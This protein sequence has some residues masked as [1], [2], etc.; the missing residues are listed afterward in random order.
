MIKKKLIKYIHCP[1]YPSIRLVLYFKNKGYDVVV[2]SRNP[3]V[4][5]LCKYMNWKMVNYKIE[6][7]LPRIRAFYKL[8]KY[9]QA[10]KR[11]LEQILPSVEKDNDLYFT[12]FGMDFDS[13]FIISKLSAFLRTFY[14]SDHDYQD[15]ISEKIDI[16]WKRKVVLRYLEIVYGLEWEIRS[17][18]G[19]KCICVTEDFFKRYNIK[20]LMDIVIDDREIYKNIRIDHGNINNVILGDYSFDFLGNFYDLGQVKSIYHFIRVIDNNTVYKGHP[21]GT[22]RDPFFA[23]YKKLPIFVPIEFYFRHI[24]NVISIDSTALINL[25]KFSNVRCL[26]LLD[27][28]NKNEKSAFDSDIHKKF[29]QKAGEGRIIFVKSFN[30]LEQHIR[31]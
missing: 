21:G 18:S 30:E 14:R 12:G 1:S 13:L 25:S 27:M 26:C 15:I 23:D 19:F 16:S 2:I 4:I 22:D 31:E 7:N 11:S 8:P 28:I 6:R 10:L 3:D 29:L 24:R 20:K 17:V 5:K 9:R